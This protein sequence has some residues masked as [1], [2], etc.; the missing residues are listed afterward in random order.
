[1]RRFLTIAIGATLLAA[2]P[3]AAS[4]QG[5]GAQMGRPGDH[6]P[7]SGPAHPGQA[8]P[9]QTHPGMDHPDMGRGEMG[10]GDMGRPGMHDD[11][12]GRWENTWG[13]RPPAPPK[14]YARRGSWYQHVR[15][16]SAR[17]RSYN[18]RTDTYQVRRGVYRTCRL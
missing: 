3:L 7:A 9:D 18:P 13:H 2:T 10:R 14:H 17:Y 4:A 6:T 11:R 5:Q 8:H 12:Y 16:C 15:A 1:M